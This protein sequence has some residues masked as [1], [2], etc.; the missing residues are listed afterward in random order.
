[1]KNFIFNRECR[2]LLETICKDTFDRISSH[3]GSLLK[4]IPQD[5]INH[6]EAIG[7]G[8]K[9]FGVQRAILKHFESKKLKF[10]MDLIHSVAMGC[11]LYGKTLRSRFKSKQTFLDD[12]NIFSVVDEFELPEFLLVR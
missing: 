1:M 5:Q 12:P 7:G 10:S 3:I 8:T 6:I 11:A 4:L 9:V 2:N